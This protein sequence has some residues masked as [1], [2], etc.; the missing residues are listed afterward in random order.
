[1]AT[2]D[3][4]AWKYSR[5]RNKINTRHGVFD[6]TTQVPQRKYLIQ[7]SWTG[8]C[9][10]NVFLWVEFT[11]TCSTQDLF[12]TIVVIGDLS[13]NGTACFDFWGTLRWTATGLPVVFFNQSIHF[14]W[15]GKLDQRK[16][17]SLFFFSCLVNSLR[18]S[19]DQSCVPTGPSRPINENDRFQLN[20][21]KN[22]KNNDK[23]SPIDLFITVQLVIIS[24]VV[25]SSKSRFS[26]IQIEWR[27]CE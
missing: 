13:S 14:S 23:S 22:F 8:L 9:N 15:N 25:I 1:M 21:V 17:P 2:R 11:V 27:I 7:P 20:L 3:Q 24:I 10:C 19:S 6:I 5:E 18:W 16:W 26:S 12:F 4:K